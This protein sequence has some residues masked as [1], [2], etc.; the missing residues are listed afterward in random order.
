[1][2]LGP[3]IYFL[4]YR[5]PLLVLFSFLALVAIRSMSAEPRWRA[6]FI[7]WLVANLISPLLGCLGGFGLLPSAVESI[8]GVVVGLG[9]L[10]PAMQDRRLGVKRD[11]LHFAGVAGRIANVGMAVVQL[12]MVSLRR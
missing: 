1:M 4:F 10:V 7:V 2:Q 12:L 8:V 3:H 9:F 11:Q 5:I 6:M